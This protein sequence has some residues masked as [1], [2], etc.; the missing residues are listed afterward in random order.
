M[1]CICTHLN[2]CRCCC[3]CLRRDWSSNRLVAFLFGRRAAQ[4][5][6]PAG[7]YSM[8]DHSLMPYVLFVCCAFNVHTCTNPRRS[9]TTIIHIMSCPS[10]LH[11]YVNQPINQ[12]IN[13]PI[14]Q[15]IKII[16]LLAMLSGDW[17]GFVFVT[18]LLNQKEDLP[19]SSFSLQ[20]Q[21]AAHPTQGQS[22]RWLD[23]QALTMAYGPAPGK[24]HLHYL[25]LRPWPPSCVTAPSYNISMY[26]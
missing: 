1:Y 13:Q 9:Q 21:T 26:M 18:N 5:P 22:L 10:H 3:F 24:L 11:H 23:M 15:S 7:K 2:T 6:V 20:H 14:N 12:S 19:P 16:C 8:V 17:N 4:L 25:I